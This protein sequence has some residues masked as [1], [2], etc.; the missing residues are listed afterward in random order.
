[1]GMVVGV[2][3]GVG[4]GVGV[5]GVILNFHPQPLKID[6]N[7]LNQKVAK[8]KRGFFRHATFWLAAIGSGSHSPFV[9]VV[10]GVG[11]VILNFHPQPL[12]IDGNKLNQKVAKTKR[13][14]FRHAT[15][16]LA[17]IGSGSHSP[18]V[19]VGV[20]VGVVMVEG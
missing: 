19:G 17:A 7:K 18:F 14:F 9:G 12:K 15:F 8:T 10:M 1:M 6:G 13:G 3:V 5:G 4:V 11:G 20:G 2:V 16:W